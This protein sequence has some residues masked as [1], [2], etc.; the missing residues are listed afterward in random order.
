MIVAFWFSNSLIDLFKVSM[1]VVSLLSLV[2]ISALF[3]KASS[4]RT[5]IISSSLLIAVFFAATILRCSSTV[6]PFNNSAKRVSSERLLITS[7]SLISPLISN[8]SLRRFCHEYCSLKYKG[9]VINLNTSSAITSLIYCLY[10]F[11]FTGT[12]FMK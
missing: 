12:S 8:S 7:S 5:G 4:I 1:S 11:S 3:L 2:A 6:L 9:L 10:S